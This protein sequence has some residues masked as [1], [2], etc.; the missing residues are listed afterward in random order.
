M[1]SG[2]SATRRIVS[3]NVTTSKEEA[4][5]FEELPLPTTTPTNTYRPAFPQSSSSSRVP[6]VKT[7]VP[8]FLIRQPVRSRREGRK[9]L[10]PTAWVDG[11]RGIAAFLVLIFH[12]TYRMTNTNL[13]YGANELSETYDL[14]RLPVIRLLSSGSAMVALFFLISGYA[15]SY[16]PLQLARAA[17]TRGDGPEKFIRYMA[18]AI[19]RRPIRLFVPVILASALIFVLLRLGVWELTRHIAQDQSIYPITPQETHTEYKDSAVEQLVH[20]YIEISDLM[21]NAFGDNFFGGNFEYDQHMWTIPVELR[22]SMLLFLSLIPTAAMKNIGTRAWYWCGLI[23]WSI[24]GGKWEMIL[25]YSGALIA[26]WDLYRLANGKSVDGVPQPASPMEDGNMSSAPE[27]PLILMIALLF[28]SYPEDQAQSTPL[29]RYLAPVTPGWF[30]QDFRFWQVISGAMLFAT[31]SQSTTLKR[32]L[33]SAPVQYLGRI[34]YG[35]YLMH[36][37]VI[38]TVGFGLAGALHS[39]GEAL[40]PA[41]YSCALALTAVAAIWAGDVWHREVDERCVRWAKVL[42]TRILDK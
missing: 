14:W 10:S 8:S 32:P 5:F 21:H 15:L 35:L 9:G 2:E 36:G 13:G 22:S 31:I 18:S 33:I 42:S 12:F 37:P 17:H 3:L 26:D 6:T 4:E 11:L 24:D 19:I 29:Y 7:L 16:R 1:D 27:T 34:S 38:H 20:W 23:L 28:F 25:F 41:E 39:P 40:G 30:A